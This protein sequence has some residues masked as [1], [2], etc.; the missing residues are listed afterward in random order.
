MP[1]RHIASWTGAGGLQ[2]LEPDQNSGV[3]R[4]VTPPTT[5]LNLATYTITSEDVM[6]GV[7]FNAAA[8]TYTMPTAAH[9][10]ADYPDW[11]IGATVTFVL[12]SSGIAVT[13][14]VSPGTGVTLAM[15]NGAG[16]AGACFVILWRDSDTTF[17]YS[18]VRASQ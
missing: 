18:L 14:T 10:L 11:P 13:K 16:I 1:F 2:S 5:G 3:W 7:I 4:N 6:R 15:G 12:A 17:K 8:C 9:L